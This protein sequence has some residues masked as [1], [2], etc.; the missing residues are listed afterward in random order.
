[1]TTMV[2]SVIDSL[3]K[4][5]GRWMDGMQ[6]SAGSWSD[7]QIGVGG[8][9][10]EWVTAYVCDAID[11]WQSS[12]RSNSAAIARAAL[13]RVQRRDGGWGY[14]ERIP[15]DTDTTGLAV[16]A[17]SRDQTAFDRTAAV[18]FLLSSHD[19]EIGGFRTYRSPQ[20]LADLYRDHP[21]RTT[22]SFEGWCSSHTEV[23]ASALEALVALGHENS[24][25]GR[26]ATAYLLS[27]QNAN[28]YWT[29]YWA[30]DLF[31]P[32][33]RAV[34]ALARVQV[35]GKVR[36]SRLVDALLDR[37]RPDGSW[38][39]ESAEHGCAFRTALAIETLC[40]APVYYGDAIERAVQWLHLA[41]SPDGHWTSGYP[42]MR[43]PPPQ[44]TNP[45]K[46]DGWGPD[47]SGIGAVYCDQNGILTSATVI[48]A[49]HGV[50]HRVSTEIST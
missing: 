44:I 5:A 38:T 32:T 8:R 17:L 48:S 15:S 27:K 50:H 2:L 19:D 42:F 23:T 9:S 34:R 37:Q 39:A 41:M 7:F 21:V 45:D 31:Y 1:M 10:D 25:Q 35:R 12:G 26:M 47:G 49:I 28:G 24:Q 6:G 29:G 46:Y 11:G 30:T 43:V 16:L 3:L 14:N 33:C 40:H 20:E 18:R 36:W 22:Q 4:T 13:R